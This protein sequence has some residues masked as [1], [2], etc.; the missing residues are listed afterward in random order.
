MEKPLFDR[1]VESMTQMSEIDR[2]EHQP[3]RTFDIGAVQVERVLQETK[4]DAGDIGQRVTLRG[5]S[6]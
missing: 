1:L 6:K 2:G 5:L 4:P 3:S